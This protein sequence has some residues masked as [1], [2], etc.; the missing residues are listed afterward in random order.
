MKYI[1]VISAN[2]NEFIK[3]VNARLEASWILS[4]GIS[5]AFQK[6]TDENGE[7]QTDTIYAQAMVMSEQDVES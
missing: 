4:G 2:R 7:N 6:Y 3:E 5:V 1:A